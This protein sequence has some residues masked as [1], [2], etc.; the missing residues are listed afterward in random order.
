MGGFII[1]HSGCYS[2]MLARELHVNSYFPRERLESFR[3]NDLPVFVNWGCGRS[4]LE[5]YVLGGRQFLNADISGSVR[6]MRTFELLDA[7]SL[8]HPR[9]VI[10]PREVVDGVPFYER[11]RYLGRTDGLTGGQGIT[12][13]ERGTLPPQGARH[14]FYSQVVSKAHEIR[15]HVAGGAVICEQFKFVPA[16]SNVLIRNYDNGARFS[17]RPLETRIESQL[18]TRL[19][20]TAI[21]AVA[22]CGLDFGALDMAVTQRGNIVIFEVNSAPGITPREDESEPHDMPCSYEAYLTYFRQFVTERPRT[23]RRR[24][25]R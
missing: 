9:V 19:R 7:A 4:L 23:Q 16:G 10:D 13:Y 14:D 20:E 2:R 12:V 8:P 15:L 18:A 3:R 17:A 25:S 5:R 24:L 22:A 1:Y 11:G 6:K 21:A